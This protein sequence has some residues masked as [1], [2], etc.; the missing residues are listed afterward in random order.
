M[1]GQCWVNA[2]PPSATLAQH[3]PSI[4]STPRSRCVDRADQTRAN[5]KLLKGVRARE[6]LYV[7]GPL[8]PRG[9]C[10][11]IVEKSLQITSRQ[12]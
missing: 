4:G 2:G 7:P 5:V 11:K 6:S 8:N 10:V 9:G 1:R 12:T 3:L